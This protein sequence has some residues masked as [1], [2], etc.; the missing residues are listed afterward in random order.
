MLP[1]PLHWYVALLIVLGLAGTF[2]TYVARESRREWARSGG[3]APAEYD[4]RLRRNRRMLLPWV[5][6]LAVFFV[7]RRAGAVPEEV[8]RWIPLVPVAL[9]TP[10]AIYDIWRDRQRLTRERNWRANMLWHAA[11]LAVLLCLTWLVMPFLL[12]LR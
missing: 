2:F 11:L 7:L 10:L 12:S 4:E 6:L 3:R 5:V 1:A 9:F 8:G